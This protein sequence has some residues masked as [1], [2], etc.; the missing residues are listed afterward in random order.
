MDIT[1]EHLH[2]GLDCLVSEVLWFIQVQ[3]CSHAVMFSLQERTGFL[4]GT[5]SNKSNLASVYLI[6]L[7]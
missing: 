1:A 2:F 6:V 5:L 3:L 4:P 7:S